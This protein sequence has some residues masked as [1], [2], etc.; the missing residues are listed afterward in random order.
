MRCRQRRCLFEC[1]S[2]A[3]RVMARTPALDLV[4]WADDGKDGGLS[5]VEG[6]R[7]Q[8]RGKCAQ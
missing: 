5:A 4:S 8:R 7:R 6:S 1:S 2:H 3:V